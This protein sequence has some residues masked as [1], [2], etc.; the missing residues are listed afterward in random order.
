MR[1]GLEMGG[2]GRGGYRWEGTR[3]GGGVWFSFVYFNCYYK[4][5]ILIELYI[6]SFKSTVYTIAIISARNIGSI[7]VTNSNV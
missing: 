1:R 2:H 4:T 3:E 7:H 6:T 5:S